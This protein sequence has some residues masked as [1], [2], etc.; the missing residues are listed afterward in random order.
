MK[1]YYSPGAC[2]LS[3][4]IA[5][6]EAGLAYTPV[7]A[8]TKSHKLQDGTDYYTI[9]ALGYVP[10]L[11][12]DNGERLR[13]GPAIVQYIAD[14]VPD[15]QLAP[16]NGTLARY[17]LQ[18]WLTFIGTELHKGFSPLFNPATPEEY[19]PMVRERLLQRLQW[20]DSQLAG[21]QYLMGDQFTVADGYLFTVTNWTQPTKLDISGLANLAA[22]R[23][24][25]G[26]RPAVQAAMKAEGLLK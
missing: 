6:Q 3:P 17:R 7:L 25:V 2:S 16:A 20:V 18:E 11:E 21:K 24:R 9:N 23:E 1:L 8:S 5:L 12:L 15:K 26:A 22:Y 14:Q 10:V 19:K 4:H 13:E